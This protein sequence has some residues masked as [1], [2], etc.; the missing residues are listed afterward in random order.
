MIGHR[1]DYNTP[2]EETV[3]FA[4]KDDSF[5]NTLV[6]PPSQM[7]ALHD[8]VK[9]GYVRYIGMSSCHAYQCKSRLLFFPCVSLTI[10]RQFML[11]K[12]SP[13]L[14]HCCLY[15]LSTSNQITLFR[16]SLPPSFLC[17]ITT[18]WYIARK[19]GKC[20]PLSRSVWFFFVPLKTLLSCLS[21][22]VLVLSL[23][24]LL[25]VVS[26]RQTK[27]A[28]SSSG[29]DHWLIHLVTIYIMVFTG[30]VLLRMC[31]TGILRSF[32]SCWLMERNWTI[33]LFVIYRSY[34]PFM[35]ALCWFDD[36]IYIIR[37]DYS[38]CGLPTLL[39]DKSGGKCYQHLLVAGFAH[40]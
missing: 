35:F 40:M 12:V 34:L 2:I 20:I 7:Q 5:A 15:T 23:G 21:F 1:F 37:V 16:T 6:S 31:A 39:N 10:L 36:C 38:I 25:L 13:R 27:Q 32:F 24:L 22:L 26:L 14:P 4:Y 30:R 8:V 33:I 28:M 3:S 9:A 29:S 18:V 11:C 19:K 17:K